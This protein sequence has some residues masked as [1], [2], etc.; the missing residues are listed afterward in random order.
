M[1]LYVL[2]WFFWEVSCVQ[3][4][5]KLNDQQANGDCKEAT[6]IPI[7]VNL[8]NEGSLFESVDVLQF[9]RDRSLTAK[10]NKWQR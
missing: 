5:S 1:N 2:P 7:Q 3:D 4:T 9:G 6:S 8:N 10:G